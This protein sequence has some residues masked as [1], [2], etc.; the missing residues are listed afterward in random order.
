[1][2]R[3]KATDESPADD[4]AGVRTP[5]AAAGAATVVAFELDTLRAAGRDAGLTGVCDWFDRRGL[6]FDLTASG[7]HRV[8]FELEHPPPRMVICRASVV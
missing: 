8:A 2:W 5:L 3:G 6:R 7:V 1:V 4:A